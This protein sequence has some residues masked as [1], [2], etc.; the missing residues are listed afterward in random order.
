MAIFVTGDTH[1]AKKFGF[2]SVDGFMN[3]LNMDSFPGPAFSAI[4]MK[5]ES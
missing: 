1:G 2:F 3:R 5:I 4:R